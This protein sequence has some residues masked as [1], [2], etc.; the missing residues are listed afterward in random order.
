[1][2]VEGDTVAS[3]SSWWLGRGE[4]D[5]GNYSRGSSYSPDAQS[6]PPPPP[7]SILT[8]ACASSFCFFFLAGTAAHWHVESCRARAHDP[9]RSRRRIS[10]REGC[11]VRVGWRCSGMTATSAAASSDGVMGLVLREVGVESAAHVK[12]L[13]PPP[14]VKALLV[15]RTGEASSGAAAEAEA[16]EWGV[17]GVSAPSQTRPWQCSRRA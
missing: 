6:T 4:K 10:R 11:P 15:P 16:K 13:A 12:S 17:Q 3:P 1:M 8:F 7:P 5:K 14:P 2:R 9:R